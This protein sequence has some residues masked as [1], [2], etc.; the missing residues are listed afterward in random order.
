M[1]I[2]NRLS[3]WFTQKETIRFIILFEGRTGS[4]WLCDMLDRHPNIKCHHE[5]LVKAGRKGGQEGV[6]TCFR[7]AMNGAI[8]N[9]KRVIGLKAKLRQV[10]DL[11]AFRQLL[12]DTHVH[13]I[14]MKRQ[15][16]IK[17]TV[18]A[19]RSAELEKRT[20]KFNIWDRHEQ[21]RVEALWVDPQR[22]R[23]KLE[24]QIER[25]QLSKDFV[26]SLSLPLIDV[27]YENLY[28]QTDNE[29]CRIHQFLTVPHH[30]AVSRV[31]K[32]TSDDLREVVLN[33]DELRAM[34]SG[35]QYEAMFEGNVKSTQQKKAA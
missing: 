18:S 8:P 11:S 14:H 22:F 21:D 1:V 17:Q 24:L 32:H 29:L 9:D 25:N 23:S 13:V 20:G 12:I 31:L 35:T 5:I 3:R 28:S 19:L 6:H 7:N 34:F 10:F 27:D 4:T 2:I 33:F 26:A 16:V 30:T 15:N